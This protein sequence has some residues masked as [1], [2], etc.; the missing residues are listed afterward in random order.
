[1]LALIVFAVLVGLAASLAKEEGKTF[2]NF[3][4][5]ANKV[6]M[7]VIRL[8]MFYAPIG[9]GAYFAYLVGTLGPELMGSYVHVITIYYPTALIYFAVGFTLYAFLAAGK[10]GVQNFWGNILPPALTAW[11]TGSSLAT[12]PV[13]FEAADRIGVPKD[14]SRVVIPIGATIHMDGT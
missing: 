3:L 4:A 14:V 10:K 11:G 7:R 1:M 9:L 5:S 6:M 12:V 2:V 8:I 13:N